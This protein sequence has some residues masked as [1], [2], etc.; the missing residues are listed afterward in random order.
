[1]W[2][3]TLTGSYTLFQNQEWEF[4]QHSLL[5]ARVDSHHLIVWHFNFIP[6]LSLPKP[7]FLHGCPSLFLYSS[8]PQSFPPHP[9][10][11]SPEEQ[12]QGCQSFILFYFFHPLVRVGSSLTQWHVHWE[13]FFVHQS[14]LPVLMS[15]ARGV[16][17]NTRILI[18]VTLSCALSLSFCTP[19]S[20]SCSFFLAFLTFGR[21][22]LSLYLHFWH[23]F[24]YPHVLPSYLSSLFIH[25]IGYVEI[26]EYWY[27]EAHLREHT[28]H[29]CWFE[30]PLPFLFKVCNCSVRNDR[31][32]VLKLA[33]A[34]P[35]LIF[36]HLRL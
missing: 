7:Q 36:L 1:M 29:A 14:D 10:I 23:L 31:N 11:L 16:H 12:F 25:F 8:A 21:L 30:A 18:C 24:Y 27:S 13:I 5:D 17:Y 34:L 28:V 9:L 6:Q 22:Y 15:P 3:C 32:S 19:Q 26:G 20:L 33:S 4:T 35:R 2:K